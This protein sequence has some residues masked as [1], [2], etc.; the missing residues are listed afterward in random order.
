METRCTT[1]LPREFEELVSQVKSIF[2]WIVETVESA[3]RGIN[4]L[5][6]KER[7]LKQKLKECKLN[8]RTA[9]KSGAIFVRNAQSFFHYADLN[10]KQVDSI[11]R[12]YKSGCKKDIRDYIKQIW[13]L[14][15]RAQT[16]HKEFM[17]K[18][19]TAK[20]SC[21]GIVEY[22]ESKKTAARNKK[23]ATRVVGS[24][25]A[26]AGAGVAGAAGV[27]GA[28]V[29]A[30]VVAGVFTFGIGTVVGLAITGAAA[31][32]VGVVTAGAAGATTYFVSRNFE[33]LEK[34]FRDLSCKFEMLTDKISGLG[35]T[36]EK[37]VQ[38]L[39]DADSDLGMLVNTH[40]SA[41]QDDDDDDDETGI[42]AT[43]FQCTQFAKALKML[44]DGISKG[45][46]L[47]SLKLPSII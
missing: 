35:L 15:Q 37:V 1:D 10:K 11:K 25:A 3:I 26:V 32:T 39:T 27:V 41:E 42:I 20:E 45:R 19:N 13:Q 16:S 31:G 33:K 14:L 17:E 34:I 36:M 44:L 9:Q 8:L 23:I 30:S 18:Y 5:D 38:D 29:A 40:I 12:S 6:V 43:E 24:G 46:S 2:D 28:G 22:C 21:D 7:E 4:S 47:T